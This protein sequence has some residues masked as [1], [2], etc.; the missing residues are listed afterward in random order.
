MAWKMHTRPQLTTHRPEFCHMTIHDTSELSE[1]LGYVYFIVRLPCTNMLTGV[2]ITVEESENGYWVESWHALSQVTRLSEIF[3]NSWT[4][5]RDPAPLWWCQIIHL[6]VKKSLLL[7]FGFQKHAKS[8][9]RKKKKY[10]AS[11]RKLLTFFSPV[12][13]YLEFL[14]MCLSWNVWINAI[15]GLIKWNWQLV[16]T[17]GIDG[18]QRHIVKIRLF[19]ISVYDIP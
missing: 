6:V 11:S 4:S 15:C 9:F 19:C 3:F 7:R 14:S 10:R 18:S 5:M 12:F 1:G 13:N 2:S 16:Q 8:G 17:L